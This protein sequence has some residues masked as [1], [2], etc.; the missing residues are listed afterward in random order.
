MPP[1]PAFIFLPPNPPQLVARKPEELPVHRHRTRCKKRDVSKYA[2]VIHEEAEGGFW[3]EVPVLPGCG[4]THDL[5]GSKSTEILV[6]R[7]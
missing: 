3:A 6:G 4:V 2:V 7:I 1:G 5:S